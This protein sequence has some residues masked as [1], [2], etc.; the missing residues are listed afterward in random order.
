MCL[1]ILSPGQ[2][3]IDFFG[4]YIFFDVVEGNLVPREVYDIFF[5]VD[6]ARSGLRLLA[7]SPHDLVRGHQ[8]AVEAITSPG[9]G[10]SDDIVY[11]QGTGRSAAWDPPSRTF[12]IV[13]SQGDHPFN[14]KDVAHIGHVVVPNLAIPER[15]RTQP[16][17]DIMA[18]TGTVFELLFQDLEPDMQ[19][20]IRL[21]VRPNR[22]LGFNERRPEESEAG[23]YPSGWWWQDFKIYC[24]KTCQFNFNQLVAKLRE[25]REFA[26]AAG[27]IQAEVQD[28]RL[29]LVPF[30][31][32]RIG[33][34]C[35]PNAAID[36]AHPC[37]WAMSLGM[38][39]L[40]VLGRA[41]RRLMEWLSGSQ[42][43]WVDDVQSFAKGIWTY[44]N[45]WAN[46]PGGAKRKEEIT[47]ALNI[48]HENCSLVVDGLCRYGA[49]QCQG[50]AYYASGLSE[51]A[52]RE[53]FA[54]MARD[55]AVVEHFFW[56]GYELT[57]SI[58][59]YY[60]S[61]H[62]LRARKWRH[63]KANWAFWLAILGILV[64]FLGLV[65]TIHFGVFSCRTVPAF[66]SLINPA[67]PALSPADQ[68]RPPTGTNAGGRRGEIPSAS[69]LES[70]PESSE[71][72]SKTGPDKLLGSESTGVKQ[73]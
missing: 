18:N 6:T 33:V 19:Y 69:A 58:R 29:A 67:P 9:A 53:V 15:L 44:L 40:V 63:F 27:T 50:T 43:Y 37:G 17:Q 5:R 4:E 48:S 54:R 12:E 31:N 65:A 23:E 24:S 16:I 36:A 22:L 25:R 68:D 66:P 49:L 1:S 72:T 28:S 38:F 41:P 46:T 30:D 62:D 14:R 8:L 45:D 64:S 56:T 32:H 35:P 70:E 51:N 34:V 21:V 3:R 13:V 2:L 47:A 59:F 55:P 42:M 61:Y 57:Y 73:E 26:E 60:L 20:A 11:R 52:K 71:F 10:S 7:I 39:S